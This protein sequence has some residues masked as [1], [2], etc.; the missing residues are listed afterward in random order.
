[1]KQSLNVLFRVLPVH[2]ISVQYIILLFGL[3]K[4]QNVTLTSDVARMYIRT[5]SHRTGGCLLIYRRSSHRN[6]VPEI[7]CAVI[8]T[9][10]F[11]VLFCVT[12]FSKSF[13]LKYRY[14]LIGAINVA[15]HSNI[16]VEK[17][18][19]AIRDTECNERQLVY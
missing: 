3:R 6:D 16:N 15:T 18:I 8:C 2:Q 12:I 5:C 4:E 10:Q 7:N 14:S 11:V 1:M 13:N 19:F 17:F 9:P